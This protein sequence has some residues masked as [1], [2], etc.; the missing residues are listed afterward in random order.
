M[1]LGDETTEYF[2]IFFM[3]IP[4]SGNE[5]DMEQLQMVLNR[6]WLRKLSDKTCDI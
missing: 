1:C 4:T 2:S 3:D 6:K 5:R